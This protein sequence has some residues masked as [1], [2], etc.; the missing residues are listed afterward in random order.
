[1]RRTVLL[2]VTMASTGILAMCGGAF[3]LNDQLDEAGADGGASSSSE[4]VDVSVPGDSSAFDA[5]DTSADDRRS[6]PPDS[7]MDATSDGGDDGGAHDAGG[8]ADGS[9]KDSGATSDGPVLSDVVSC[10]PCDGSLVAN[11]LSAAGCPV[12]PLGSQGSN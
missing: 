10:L 1:M 3:S 12:C 6:T 8:T 4:G 2:L 11:G 7:G 5:A 9:M